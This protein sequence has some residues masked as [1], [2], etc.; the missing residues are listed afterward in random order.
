MKSGELS[1][2]YSHKIGHQASVQIGLDIRDD[3]RTTFKLSMIK[4]EEIIY[5][6]ADLLGEGGF[7]CVFR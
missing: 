1:S 6:K 2:P 4:D 3:P 5:S 7:G